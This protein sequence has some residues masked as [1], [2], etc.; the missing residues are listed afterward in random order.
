MTRDRDVSDRY[1]RESELR[2]RLPFA[3]DTCMLLP[4]PEVVLLLDPAGQILEGSDKFAGERLGQLSFAKRQTAH[5]ALHPGCDG[6]NCELSADWQR[7][8]TAHKSGLPVEW[9]FRS[10]SDG[11]CFKLRLQSVGYACSVLFGDAIHSYD[12]CSVL[13]IQ[14]L[15]AAANNAVRDHLAGDVEIRNA[16]IYQLRGATDPDLVASLDDRLRTLTGR[17]LL[18]QEAERKR[19]AAELH[20][21][22]GQTLSLLHFEIEACLEQ[23][24]AQGETQHLDDIERCVEHSERA[25]QEL[26]GITRNLRP[27]I[28][29]D[30]GLIG[31]LDVLC[32]D[33][34]A[35]KPEIELSFEVTGR[36][37]SVPV[38]LA[39]NIYRI[40]QEALNNVARHAE[41]KSVALVLAANDEGVGIEVRDDGVGLPEPGPPPNGLGL[42]TT[43]E[44]AET[45]GGHY[46]IENVSG[47]G[48]AIR[49]FWPRDAIKSMG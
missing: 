3:R 14:D 41:A 23:V 5:N 1:R 13:F 33:F 11:A 45:L 29:E 12:D 43:R 44:R 21:G 48:C 37:R 38:N 10:R 26:R 35:V 34:Q 46:D 15:S 6:H 28:I 36:P 7:A 24:R 22:L 32:S 40:A 18:S 8:W 31:A 42:L 16:S 39:V 2:A 20:D 17:L 30:L 27:T 49:V 47:G 9:F 25:L 4:T 19:I